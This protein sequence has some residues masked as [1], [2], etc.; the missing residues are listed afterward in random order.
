[1][2][3]ISKNKRKYSSTPIV[4]VTLD[5]QGKEQEEMVCICLGKKEVGDKMAETIVRLLNADEDI[6]KLFEFFKS[7]HDVDNDTY[8][9]E[10][11]INEVLNFEFD[12]DDK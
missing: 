5:E 7:I 11:L 9:N 1:M 12:K 8:P 10:K 3:A 4:K 2:Y 6:M